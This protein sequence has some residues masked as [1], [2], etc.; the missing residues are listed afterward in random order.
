MIRQAPIFTH[1]LTP[2][3]FTGRFGPTEEDYQKVVHYA[4]QH[5]FTVTHTHAN[6]MMVN[7]D[8]P[9]S[10]IEK[11]FRSSCTLPASDGKSLFYAPDSEPT[12]ETNI[13]ILHIAGLDNY[14]LPHRFNT[15]KAAGDRHQLDCRLCQRS[16]PGGNF[17]G[18]DFRTAMC[19]GYQYWCR[20]YIAIVDVGGPYYPLDVYMYE[21]NAGLFH[22]HRRDNI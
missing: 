18:K 1:W 16:G 15:P 11:R 9:V 6:R 14:S 21:T 13:P 2:E 8:A 12:V 5:G 7:V 20:Q 3:D 10:E 19:P 4:G 22:E 17:M